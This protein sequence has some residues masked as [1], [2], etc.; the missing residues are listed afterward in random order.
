VERGRAGFR[1]SLGLHPEWGAGPLGLPLRLLTV[2]L[3]A[4]AVI[5][6]FDDYRS[7]LPLLNAENAT[8][9]PDLALVAFWLG[10][11]GLVGLVLSGDALRVAAALLTILSGFDLIYA[12]VEPNLA[13]VGFLGALALL[14]ALAFSYLVVVQGLGASASP[15]RAATGR[16]WAGARPAPVEDLLQAAGPEEGTEP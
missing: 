2:I 10:G 4:L 15:A 6:F 8:V 9:P 16:P 7:L 13:V 12:S 5:R 1:L 11:M 3:V 14:G